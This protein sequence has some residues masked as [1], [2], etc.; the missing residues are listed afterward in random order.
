MHLKLHSKTKS[1]HCK[2]VTK[3]IRKVLRNMTNFWQK[4]WQNLR[5]IIETKF[6][7]CNHSEKPFGALKSYALGENKNLW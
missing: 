2:N 3:L 7:T 6:M 5:N 4:R 1:F